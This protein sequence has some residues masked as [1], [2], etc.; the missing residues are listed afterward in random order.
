MVELVGVE[1]L[2]SSSLAPRYEQIFSQRFCSDE[3][4]SSIGTLF[5]QLNS[6]MIFSTTWAVNAGFRPR[7]GTWRLAGASVQALKGA[8]Y[9]E[10]S[11]QVV[12][13][14]HR[15]NRVRLIRSGCDG[16]GAAL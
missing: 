11:A 9:P 8:G 10:K 7:S 15:R 6:S 14:A 12:L 4:A 1:V 5:W 3:F 13:V 16:T 2:F